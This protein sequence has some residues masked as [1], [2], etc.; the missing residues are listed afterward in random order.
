MT[1]KLFRGNNELDHWNR[2]HQQ[3]YGHFGKTYEEFCPK[4]PEWETLL[5]ADQG[6]T[7]A[8]VKE[9]KDGITRKSLLDI[10]CAHG[11]MLWYMKK[12]I[13]PDWRVVGSDFS[14]DMINE[15][16]KRSSD[17]EWE[18]RDILLNPLNEDFGIVTCLQTIEHFQEG[19]NYRFVDNVLKHCEYFMLGTVDTVDDCFG[20]HISHYTLETMEQRGYNVVWKSKLGRVNSPVPGDFH[21]IAWL[22]K[23]NLA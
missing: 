16:R 22:I 1:E 5:E 3:S 14:V 23:G 4:H 7:I 19:V 10:G 9:N 11:G 12:Y 18:Q 6:C 21:T 20:E 15:N 13:I 2:K 17:V 8:I